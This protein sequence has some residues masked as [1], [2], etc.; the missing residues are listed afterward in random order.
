MKIIFKW[1]RIIYDWMG[2]KV[3]SPYASLWLIGLFFIEAFCFVIPVDP[4]LIL[5]CNRKIIC[6]AAPE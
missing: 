4:L 5:F 6:R 3:H 2:T 1:I